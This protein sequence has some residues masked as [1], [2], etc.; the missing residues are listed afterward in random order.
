MS[1]A[2][3]KAGDKIN[4]YAKG[5]WY[6]VLASGSANDTIEIGADGSDHRALR[7]VRQRLVDLL[8]QLRKLLHEAA[9]LVEQ[10]EAGTARSDDVATAGALHRSLDRRHVQRRVPVRS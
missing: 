6:K 8:P 3:I 9:R 5:Q 4:I 10:C 7:R 2:L 1:D